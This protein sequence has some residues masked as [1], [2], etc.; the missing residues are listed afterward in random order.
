MQMVQGL[1]RL[2]NSYLPNLILNYILNFYVEIIE[3]TQVYLLSG[4]LGGRAM[5]IVFT[6]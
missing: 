3:N 2:T 1:K 5:A 6:R 4:P